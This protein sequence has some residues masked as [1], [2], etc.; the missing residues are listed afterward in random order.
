MGRSGKSV[1]ITVV[2]VI[3]AI[4]LTNV[5]QFFVWRSVHN[6]TIAGYEQQI[7]TMK[8]TLA[9]VGE[10]VNVYT[11][12]TGV[13]I[14]PGKDI[15]QEDLEPVSIPSSFVRDSYIMDPSECIGK[16]Y[17]IKLEPGTPL[18]KDLMMDKDI[19][20]T[21]RDMDI[22]ADSWPVAL[23][24]GDYVDLEIT[25]GMGEKYI[26]LSHVRINA[27]NAKTLKVTLNGTER[28]MYSAML[29]DYFINRGKGTTINFVKY[30]E[31]G[32]QE[33]AKEFYAVPKNIVAVITA[34][35][36]ILDKVSGGLNTK[37][38]GMIDAAIKSTKAES[39]MF[40]DIAGG[41]NE[42]SGKIGTAVTE[43]EQKEKA[44]REKAEYEALVR[45]G[46]PNNQA[47]QQNNTQNDTTS[48][49][50]NNTGSQPSTNSGAAQNSG[51]K[52]VDSTNN[53]N[54]GEGVVQ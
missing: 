26:V 1:T 35:P 3:I 15:Q 33:A 53:L 27:I 46:D 37:L 42:V 11:V 23:K 19:D 29:V 2:V 18:T 17:K 10:L 6:N 22:I 14:Y 38:R 41:R 31:P 21:S 7:S 9:S 52:S 13:D 47:N 36:N 50:S 24:V 51:N 8:T 45:A 5:M 49:P 20:D 43:A 28:Y 39:Q 12:K 16:L 4:L 48:N 54:I 44:A 25:Y 32:V 40:N 34:D 30:V